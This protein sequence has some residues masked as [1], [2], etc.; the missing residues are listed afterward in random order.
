MPVDENQR[1]ALVEALVRFKSGVPDSVRAGLLANLQVQG[2]GEVT[3]VESA[4][5][6]RIQLSS[7]TLEQA[8]TSAEEIC[9]KL[10]ANPVT[11]T[12]EVTSVNWL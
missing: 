11:E 10:L 12:Y 9:D 2:F 1:I 3:D 7:V 8:R 5:Y 6:F 4:K